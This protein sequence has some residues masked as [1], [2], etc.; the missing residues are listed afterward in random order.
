MAILSKVCTPDNFESRNSKVSFTNIGGLLSNFVDGESFRESNSSDILPPY[1][2]SLDDSTDSGSFSVRGYLPLI[3]KD[4]ATHMH[5]LVVYVKQ[6]L[7]FARDFS[8]ENS[9][10]FYLCF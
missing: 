9:A 3:R 10:D 1:E 8:L 7:P 5:F 6:E 2:T 4:S